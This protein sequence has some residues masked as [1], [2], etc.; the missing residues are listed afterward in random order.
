MKFLKICEIMDT[1]FR[2][3]CQAITLLGTEE[4]NRE[5]LVIRLWTRPSALLLNQH[6]IVRMHSAI[7]GLL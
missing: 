7:Q 1:K 5:M 4:E 6:K 2:A 3:E